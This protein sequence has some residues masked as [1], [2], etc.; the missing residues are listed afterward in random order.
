MGTMTTK[1]RILGKTRSNRPGME[2]VPVKT[3]AMPG[4]RMADNEATVTP[5]VATQRTVTPAVGADTANQSANANDV[6]GTTTATKGAGGVTATNTTANQ[7]SSVAAAPTAAEVK[8]QNYYD[9]MISMLDNEQDKHK[10]TDPKEQ[11]KLARKKKRDA[12]F[13]AIGDGI[14][15][16]SNLY[17]TT[18]GAN[19]SYDPKSSL[20]ARMRERWDRYKKDADD[21]RDARLNILTKKYYWCPLKL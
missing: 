17:F 12:I 3:A 5:K 21:N 16:L 14:S 8:R 7:P 18:K 6:A 4:Q 11:E 13:S 19:N 15:A 10:A 9:D 2:G 1:D 20:S